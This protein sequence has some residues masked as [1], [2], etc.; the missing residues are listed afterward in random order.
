MGIANQITAT[1]MSRKCHMI[2]AQPHLTSTH[3][4]VTELGKRRR[5]VGSSR[6]TLLAANCWKYGEGVD[7]F[8]N[9]GRPIDLPPALCKCHTQQTYVCMQ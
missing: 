7:V 9:N 1:H 6:D 4:Y 2:Y 5:S 3:G 8:H